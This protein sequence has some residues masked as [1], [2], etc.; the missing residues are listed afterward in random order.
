ME[1]RLG[2][3]RGEIA[4][5]L[6]L[7]ADEQ[8]REALEYDLLALG[9][10]LDDLGTR[11]LSWRDLWVVVRQAPRSSAIVLATDPDSRW[12]LPEQLLAAA[13]DALRAANWQRGRA[14]RHEY[15]KP[16]PRPGVE[17]ESKT[18][19]GEALPVDEMNEWLGWSDVV[20]PW[21]PTKTE[22]TDG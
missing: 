6:I 7:L 12:G 3:R 17:P 11:R 4:G 20:A 8:K 1:G 22:V 14:R 5:L 2:A 16:I 15:P 13:V 21:R 9:L 10:R 18:F 19:G